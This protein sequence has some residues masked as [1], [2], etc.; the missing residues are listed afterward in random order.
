[1]KSDPERLVR[2]TDRFQAGAF[3]PHGKLDMW[4]EGGDAEG[5]IIYSV[6]EGPFNAEF[7]KAYV[8]ARADLMAKSGRP[9]LRAHILQMKRSMMASPDML[10]AYR[11]LLSGAAAS[12]L[13]AQH[14]AWVVGPEVEG[15]D[16]MLPLFEQLYREFG[17]PFAAFEHLPPA[18]AWM[19]SQLVK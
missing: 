16:F 18:E 7:L 17:L 2:S 4:L 1:M 6:A 12:H 13:V 15:R 3:R 5:V 9:H 14:T 19:R 11:R 10:E 8:L